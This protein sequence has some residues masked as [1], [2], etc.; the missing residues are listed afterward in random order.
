MI[1]KLLYLNV[2][3]FSNKKGDNGNPR[4]LQPLPI[5]KRTWIDISMDFIEGPPNSY[6]KSVIMVVLDQISNY[7]YFFPLA[8]PY[9]AFNVAQLFLDNIFK[10]HS[11]PSTI[12]SDHDLT[13]ISKFW[14]EFFKLQATSLNMS[15]DYHPQIYSQIE[16]INKYLETYFYYFSST[17]LVHWVKWL[18]LIKW[19]YNTSYHTSI[20]MTPYESLYGKH[21]SIVTSYI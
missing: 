15:F 8:H 17:Q 11:M 19:W 21:P 13:F 12:V 10:L 2:R 16:T 6:G 5:L 1:S 14:Q 20:K 3:F 18:P 4:L 9:K 7:A